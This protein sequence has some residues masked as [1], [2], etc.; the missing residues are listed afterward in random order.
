[1]SSGYNLESI[2]YCLDPLLPSV[3]SLSTHTDSHRLTQT[4]TLL[5]LKSWFSHMTSSLDGPFFL[6]TSS[7]SRGSAGNIPGQFGME[8]GGGNTVSRPRPVPCCRCIARR[9]LQNIWGWEAHCADDIQHPAGLPLWGIVT[10]LPHWGCLEREGDGM[11]RVKQS[12]LV[13][14][15]PE[16]EKKKVKTL[17]INVFVLESD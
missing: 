7:S 1:M 4:Q 17:E 15:P 11:Q 14:R 12:L 2:H 6:M 13:N 16:E 8:A 3:S 9:V 10:T 5:L